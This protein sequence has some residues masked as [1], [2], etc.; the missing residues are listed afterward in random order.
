MKYSKFVSVFVAATFMAVSITSFMPA[1]ASA[2]VGAALPT[3]CGTVKGYVKI[4]NVDLATGKITRVIDSAARYYAT[5]APGAK[6]ECVKDIQRMLNASY[7][8]AGTKLTVDGSY[9]T[10]TKTA[11]TKMQKNVSGYNIRF[12]GAKMTVDGKVGPQTWS[13]LSTRSTALD[14]RYNPCR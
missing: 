12:N 4:T 7:C 8:T 5:Q 11:I 10:Q 2:I 14:F 9:G 6:N 3:K 13:F 1:P